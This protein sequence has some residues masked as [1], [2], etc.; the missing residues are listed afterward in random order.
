[1]V[2][3]LNHTPN[4]SHDDDIAIRTENILGFGCPESPCDIR[5][6]DIVY[7][8]RA[9]ANFSIW[10]LAQND[11]RNLAQDLPRVCGDRLC[12]RQMACVVLSDSN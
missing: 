10:D 8:G 3:N 6:L 1:M 12:M 11:A 4:V 7:A 2:L 5:L 9:A